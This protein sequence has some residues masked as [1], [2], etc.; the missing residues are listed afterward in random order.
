MSPVEVVAA[1]L[2][3]SSL[4]VRI[5][6]DA[7]DFGDQPTSPSDRGRLNLRA[8]L[9]KVMLRHLIIQPTQ[10]KMMKRL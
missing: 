1:G 8:R 6:G 5:V 10:L 4:L 2:S 7:K 9:V 3:D